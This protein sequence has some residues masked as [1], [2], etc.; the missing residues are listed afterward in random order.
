MV[1]KKSK[2]MIAIGLSMGVA[3]Y[4]LL[5]T[6]LPIMMRLVFISKE[7]FKS[8]PT[9]SS[10]VSSAI[11]L[12]PLAL[13]AYK[14]RQLTSQPIRDLIQ[15]ELA[16]E[17]EIYEIDHSVIQTDGSNEKIRM[18]FLNAAAQLKMDVSKIVLLRSNQ[19]MFNAF[20]LSNRLD[21]GMVVVFDGL[22]NSVDDQKLQAVIGHELGHIQNK[23]SIHKTAIFASQY[24]IPA[25][26][27]WNDRFLAG[28]HNFALNFRNIWVTLFTSL[29]LLGFRL[30]ALLLTW[31]LWLNR[32]VN[33]YAFKQS[34]YLA[35]QIGSQASSKEAMM[36]VLADIDQL[37][38][39]SGTKPSALYA[40]LAEHPHTADRVEHI[41]SL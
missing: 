27:G 19:D 13:I 16:T 7:M 3:G 29:L 21:E 5:A 24:Y 26:I 37:E 18:A 33:A 1:D 23:D 6:S 20:A 34:E 28:I 2:K 30:Q 8:M 11:M 31:A 12:S 32:L 9:I 17:G 25:S 4:A 40:L 10:F 41:R 38:R 35:D 22:V 39:R 36:G 15:N 14:Y